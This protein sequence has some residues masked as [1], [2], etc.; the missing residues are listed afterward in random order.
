[1]RIMITNKGVVEDLTG[2][3][4]LEQN[5]TSRQ[6]MPEQLLFQVL[7]GLVVQPTEQV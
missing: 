7:H 6:A 4:L 1:M 3:P 5:L 2:V